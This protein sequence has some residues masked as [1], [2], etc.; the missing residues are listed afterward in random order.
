MQDQSQLNSQIYGQD[1]TTS[2]GPNGKPMTINRTE[3]AFKSPYGTS[4]TDQ[5]SYYGALPSKGNSNYMPVTA[6]FSSFGK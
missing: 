4:S 3:G 2:L 6:D 1:N 5:Y